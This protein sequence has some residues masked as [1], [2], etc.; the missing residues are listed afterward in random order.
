MKYHIIG[1]ID[2]LEKKT[3]RILVAANPIKEKSSPFFRSKP[4]VNYDIDQS[5]VCFVLPYTQEWFDVIDKHLCD[6]AEGIV[7]EWE[8]D[9]SEYVSSSQIISGEKHEG[10]M[11]KELVRQQ[12]A[13]KA[14]KEKK[15]QEIR[16][17]KRFYFPP[18]NDKMFEFRK[19]LRHEVLLYLASVAL[20]TDKPEGGWI[21]EWGGSEYFLFPAERG[22]Q[23]LGDAM[24][25]QI[26]KH[27]YWNPNLDDYYKGEMKITHPVFGESKSVVR[28]SKELSD[29]VLDNLN[30]LQL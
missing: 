29:E 13:M 21:E 16:R 27:E 20:V 5:T 4:E 22:K 7:I 17:S 19:I 2:G 18:N 14:A 26:K 30:L 23:I 9:M 12:A 10:W 11:H 25:L 6:E 3:S 28:I 15:R 24:K 8:P 1:W